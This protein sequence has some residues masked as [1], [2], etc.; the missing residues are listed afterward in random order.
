MYFHKLNCKSKRLALMLQQMK[1]NQIMESL[2]HFWMLN[3]CQMFALYFQLALAGVCSQVSC[4]CVCIGA[5]GAWLNWRE[6]I[7]CFVLFFCSGLNVLLCV[8]DCSFVQS[9]PWWKHN[10]NPKNSEKSRA[11]VAGWK[12]SSVWILRFS[13]TGPVQLGAVTLGR[14]DLWAAATSKFKWFWR[15]MRC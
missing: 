4:V 2:K 10:F 12:S 14:K 6:H 15:R 7:F 5:V 1:F 11:V 13:P 3:E 9:S 8:I